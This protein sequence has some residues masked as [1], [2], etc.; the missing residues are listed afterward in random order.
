MYTPRNG[1]TVS[2]GSNPRALV[3]EVALCERGSPVRCSVRSR[4]QRSCTEPALESGHKPA[5][6]SGYEV[7][8]SK[9]VTRS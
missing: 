9:G 2:N 8:S 7:L 5:V 4:I 3:G 1:S 6:E